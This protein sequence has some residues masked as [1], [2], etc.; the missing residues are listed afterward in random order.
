MPPSTALEWSRNGLMA[1]KLC[2]PYAIAVSVTRFQPI[3]TLMGDSRAAPETVLS[4]TIRTQTPNDGISHGRMVSHPSNRVP[5][6][7]RI[8]A[9]A[10]WSWIFQRA[11]Q[12]T[13]WKPSLP[14]R[15][16]NCNFALSIM[17]SLIHCNFRHYWLHWPMCVLYYWVV[18]TSAEVGRSPCSGG[19]GRSMSTT[20]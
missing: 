8:Y 12:T 5:D 2:K 11:V 19:V 1:W 18:K 7:C 9:N 13:P 16:V 3:W 15:L 14:S 4:A 10:H 6:T 20:F 17:A